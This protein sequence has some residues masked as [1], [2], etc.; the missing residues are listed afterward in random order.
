[1]REKKGN[2]C[3]NISNLRIFGGKDAGNENRR[4]YIPFSFGHLQGPVFREMR[5]PA[6]LDGTGNDKNW[7]EK[8][9]WKAR[10]AESGRGDV[11]G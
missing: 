8:A 5:H 2:I 3:F 10:A 7:R 6:S 11:A 9:G 1:M 4:F